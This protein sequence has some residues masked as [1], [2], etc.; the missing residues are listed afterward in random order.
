DQT[1]LSP[2]WYSDVFNNHIDD[3]GRLTL[4]PINSLTGADPYQGWILVPGPLPSVLSANPAEGA[5]AV[6]VTEPI[7]AVFSGVMD[8]A[9]INTTTFTLAV[10]AVP[11]PGTV[12]YD[13]E[14]TTATFTPLNPLVPNTLY[15]ATITTGATDL[16]GNKLS[17]A[18]VWNFTTTVQ[19]TVPPT[20]TATN[21]GDKA[22]FVAITTPVTVTFS[23]EIDPFALASS[24]TLEAGTTPIMGTVSYIP[25]IRTAI[26]TPSVPLANHTTYTAAI[27]TGVTDRGGNPVTPPVSWSF[28]TIPRETVLPII[29]ATVPAS[30]SINVQI[31][32]PI[33]AFFSEAMDPATINSATFKFTTA[34]VPVAGT[35][36]Y[37]AATNSASFVP[38]APLAFSTAYSASITTAVTDPAGNHLPLARGWSFTTA[39]PDTVPPTVTATSPSDGLTNVP[40]TAVVN[41]TF[42]EQIDTAT[43]G[44][45]TLTV[46]G[47]SF[48]ST[49]PFSVT[50]TLVLSS[51]GFS[52]P[53]VTFTPGAPLP[54]GTAFTAR[55]T[56][57]KDLA[58]NPMAADKT[59]SFTTMPDGIL[60][61]GQAA[62]SIAD[63]LRT[64]DIAAKLVQPTQD[65]RN[66]GDVAPLGLDGKPHP[67]G[68]MDITDALVILRKVV[69]LVNW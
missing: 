23:E 34:G 25:A 20:V 49:A 24:F 68:V 42:S 7:T 46:T 66:H 18:K 14:A 50:G 51:G 38:T 57:V 27:S 1:T 36:V 62:P 21:P 13:P 58:G 44:P 15:T 17:T 29:S 6:P 41:A 40:A 63:A 53:S 3:P 52:L 47:Q 16:A 64:L 5:G 61:P 33:T 26:F 67:D 54:L 59:W 9:T 10:G 22:T 19:D 30:R 28:T 4:A 12:S 45:A 60:S 2:F 31:N 55:I 39:A 35:V 8:P 43:I 65:D 32:S 69:N 11:V 37:D 48:S 56:G